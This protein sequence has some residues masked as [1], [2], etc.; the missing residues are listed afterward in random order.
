MFSDIILEKKKRII[1]AATLVIEVTLIELLKDEC[2][3]SF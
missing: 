3:F 1:A 2:S